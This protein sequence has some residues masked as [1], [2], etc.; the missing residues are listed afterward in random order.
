ML[1]RLAALALAATLSL[2][3]GAMAA[4]PLPG[5][6]GEI[7]AEVARVMNAE[8]R[9]R[10]LRALAPSSQLQQIAQRH[11]CDMAEH[12]IRSHTGSNGAT[13]ARRYRSGGGCGTGG[14]N[15]A[16]GQRTPGSAVDWWMNSPPHRAN[17]LHRQAVQYGIGVAVSNG[18]PNWVMVVGRGC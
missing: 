3:S 18:R 15:I 14:E 5:N 9:S 16:W 17:I 10:G 2:A 7:V 1:F 12:G 8:R 4:C 13:F 6:A 11:A